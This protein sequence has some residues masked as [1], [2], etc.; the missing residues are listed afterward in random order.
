[1]S[2]L[3][4]R[5]EVAF[6]F[7]ETLSN[8]FNGILRELLVLNDKVMQI[9]PQ[10]VCTS[11]AAVPIKD[12]EEANLRPLDVQVH[13]VLWLEDVENDRDS[14]L[15]IVPNDALVC[16]CGIRLDD[17]TLLLRGLSRLVVLELNRFRIQRGRILSKQK[18]LHLNELDVGVLRL[19]TADRGRSSESVVILW[20]IV[21]IRSAGH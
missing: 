10:V 12:S 13:F 2:L 14:I 6:A 9:V 11:T 15:V 21:T 8:G 19:L 20:P 5:K 7:P 18:G 1:M 16:V 4:K 3:D 17:A